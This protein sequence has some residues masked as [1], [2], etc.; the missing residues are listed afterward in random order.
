M[1]TIAHENLLEV[2]RSARLYPKSLA[3]TNMLLWS[4]TSY[5]DRQ[6]HFP[7]ELVPRSRLN[8]NNN[9]DTTVC[10]SLAFLFNDLCFASKDTRLLIL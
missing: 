10:V 6:S 2:L 7:A 4:P 9:A 5:A 8:F 1:E 3:R